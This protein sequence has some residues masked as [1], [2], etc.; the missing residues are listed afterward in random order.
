MPPHVHCMQ[1]SSPRR[2]TTQPSMTTIFLIT[3]RLFKSTR[4]RSFQRSCDRGPWADQC[5]R[6][7]KIWNHLRAIEIPLANSRMPRSHTT[8]LVFTAERAERRCS[9]RR[10]MISSSSRKRRKSLYQILWPS[11]ANLALASIA[12]ALP[13]SGGPHWKAILKSPRFKG[14]TGSLHF[15]V[16]RVWVPWSRTSVVNLMWTDLRS[17]LLMSSKPCV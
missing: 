6:R 12:K 1:L 2:M 3:Q 5:R 7:V 11:Q 16:Q 10:G 15:I 17:R 8:F 9:T 4:A 13:A 14:H